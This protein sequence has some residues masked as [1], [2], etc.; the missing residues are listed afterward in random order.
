MKK[1]GNKKRMWGLPK[2]G[3]AVLILLVLSTSVTTAIVIKTLSVEQIDVFGGNIQGTSFNIT[4]MTSKLKGK[5]KVII[6]MVIQN[7]DLANAHSA[8]I[9]VQLTDN[10]GSLLIE[11][12]ATTGVSELNPQFFCGASKFL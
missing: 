2:W 1:Q 12:A 8:D 5:N 10:D 3:L 6:D 4:E 11:S 7:T 9:E